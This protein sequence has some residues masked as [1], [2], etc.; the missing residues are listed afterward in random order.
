M[1]PGKRIVIYATSRSNLFIREV[2][3]LV[4]AGFSDL[5]CD[6]RMVFDEIPQAAPEDVLQ[7]V[8]TP[9][10]YYNLFLLDRISRQEARRLTRHLILLCTEEPRTGWFE[11]NLRWAYGARAVADINWLDVE[12]SRAHDIPAVHLPLGF[13]E[14]LAEPQQKP[15]DERA[16][17]IIFLGSLTSR[18]EKFFAR[19]AEFFSQHNCHL[20][21][22]PLGFAKT[23]ISR[24]YLTPARRNALLTDSKLLLNVHYS[25]HEYFE[26]HRRLLGLANGCCIITEKCAGYAP[27][28]PNKHFVMVESDGLIDACQYYLARPDE[29]A[30]IATAGAE[31][32]RRELRQARRANRPFAS[33][34]LVRMVL[35]FA[36]INR[37]PAGRRHAGCA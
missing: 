8:L 30:R 31:F 18:R 5:G 33:L 3:E 36:W 9:H 22:V 37:N 27:L 26:W 25:G 1:L 28:I 21:F 12:S 10:E 15:S 29:C 2:G 4:I 16:I 34:R 32:V 24:S 19:H 20:R 7:I 35:Y 23:E 14:I 17:D 11:H 6:A 13:H